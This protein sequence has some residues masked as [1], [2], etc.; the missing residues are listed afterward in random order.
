[1]ENWIIITAGVLLVLWLVYGIGY[2]AC[3]TTRLYKEAMK[4][5]SPKPNP[6]SHGFNEL[7]E[8][9]KLAAYYYQE[10]CDLR[11]AMR[12][13]QHPCPDVKHCSCVPLLQG[14][15]STLRKELIWAATK[16]LDLDEITFTR[17]CDIGMLTRDEMK[18]E[19]KKAETEK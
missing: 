2:Y 3:D 1:M 7:L 8:A 10:L 6:P 11:Q 16:L 19:M 15:I 17:A 18:K 9:K 4:T 13:A 12:G 14:V 5:R